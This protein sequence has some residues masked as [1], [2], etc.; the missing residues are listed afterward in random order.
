MLSALAGG[1]ACMIN[2]LALR[3]S[4]VAECRGLELSNYIEIFQ[5]HPASLLA[6]ALVSC[7]PGG[8]PPAA[9]PPPPVVDGWGSCRPALVHT[10]QYVSL[11]LCLLYSVVPSSIVR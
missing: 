3:T 8:P 1:F 6:L 2:V 11:S 9:V 10:P 5:F 7:P 4:A